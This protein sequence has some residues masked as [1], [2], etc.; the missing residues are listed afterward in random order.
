MSWTQRSKTFSMY[1]NA[2]FS[3]ILFTNLS[4]SVLVRTSP[5]AE[6]IHLPHRCG[7]SRCW[8]D[9][10]IIAQVCLRLAT[11][12]GHSKICSF[13]VLGGGPKTSQYLRLCH[14]ICLTHCN[15]IP[16]HRVDQ[17]VDLWPVECWSTLQWPCEVAGYWQELEH[18]VENA[19]PEHLK[20]APWVSCPV[21]MLAMQEL[22]C[23]QLPGIVY[24]SLQHR[25]VHYHAATWG[26][27]RGWMA[28]QW[29]SGSH[30]GISVHSK[31]HQWNAP[32]FVVNNIRLPIP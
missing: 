14:T 32:V 10:M 7:I 31:C 8:L 19:D 6:I 23:F 25:A 16:L 13:T 29:A 17:V 28:Q 2:Y 26:D 1:T 9:S 4:K 3:Q 24:R 15:T 12:K 30:H 21:S 20:R 22:G 5:F 18:A 11:I 27:G